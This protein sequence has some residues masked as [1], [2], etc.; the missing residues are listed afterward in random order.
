M[1]NQPGMSLDKFRQEYETRKPDWDIGEPQ[2]YFVKTFGKSRPKS[3]VLDIGCGTGDLSSY[4]ASLGCEV[5]GIDFA[6]EAIEIAKGRSLE[7]W[8][9]LTFQVEDV[10]SLPNLG[11]Q[12]QTILDCGFFHMLD[13]KARVRYSSILHNILEPGG[14]LYMLN[15]A[16]ELPAPN[17]PRCVTKNDISDTFKAGWLITD[18]GLQLL[19]GINWIASFDEALPQKRLDIER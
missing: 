18:I 7:Q 13:D 1:N 8:P 2:N 19:G 15:F 6:P 12:Y 10:F 17:A 14:K 5:T 16:V 11:K 3:P 4:I 9:E